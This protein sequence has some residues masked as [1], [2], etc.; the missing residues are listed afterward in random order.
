MKVT[1][2]KNEYMNINKLMLIS[3]VLI[4]TI[5]DTQLFFSCSKNKLEHTQE[6]VEKDNGAL[7]NIVIDY[8]KDTLGYIFL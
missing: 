4:I 3:M 5:A 1:D 7:K 6:N 8:S 2:T